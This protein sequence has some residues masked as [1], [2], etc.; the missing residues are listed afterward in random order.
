MIKTFD[1]QLFYLEFNQRLNKLFNDILE[2]STETFNLN[3]TGL[4]FLKDYSYN[5]YEIENSNLLK[6]MI[7]FTTKIS[8]SNLMKIEIYYNNSEKN[9]EYILMTNNFEQHL[10][11]YCPPPEKYSSGKKNKF[12]Y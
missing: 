12:Y 8:S 7:N 10:D 9:D 6:L 4:T 5:I 2:K 3:I 1:P 11:E